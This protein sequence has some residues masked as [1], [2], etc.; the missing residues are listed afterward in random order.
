MEHLERK[1]EALIFSSDKPVSIQEITQVLVKNSHG[2]DFIETHLIENAINHLIN[3]YDDARFSFQLFKTGGGY[4]FLSKSEYHPLI[5]TLLNIRSNKN[6]SLAALETISIVAYK[7]PVT[8]SE[9]ESIRGVNCDYTLNK[10][11]EKGLV[12][13][14]GRAATP[15][16]PLLYA[17]SETFMNY[18]GLNSADDLPKLTDLHTEESNSIGESTD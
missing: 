13:I 5:A 12:D 10:L 11:L 17:T 16:R 8:K 7:Q 15:G 18:F 2:E 14:K 4:Q 6:L 1:I 3:Q 9:I